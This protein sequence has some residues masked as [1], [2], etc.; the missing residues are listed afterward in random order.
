MI[1]G[2]IA[3]QSVSD[4]E[5]DLQDLKRSNP[6]PGERWYD[7]DNGVVLRWPPSEKVDPTWAALYC[8]R[9]H[10]RLPCPACLNGVFVCHGQVERGGP[11][12]VDDAGVE[13][14]GGPVTTRHLECTGCGGHYIRRDQRGFDAELRTATP[15]AAAAAVDVTWIDREYMARLMAE[16][17]SPP[18][19]GERR[20]DPEVD[21]F[22][23]GRE[24]R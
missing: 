10:Q 22:A 13:L 16:S 4:S 14:N 17:E 2:P 8:R 23:L 24:A 1:I 19:P 6:Q 5:Y 18:A 3:L 12:L 21:V 20:P 9:A 15:F 7:A 11:L